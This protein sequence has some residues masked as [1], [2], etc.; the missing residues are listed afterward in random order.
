ME[1]DYDSS[2]LDE[3]SSE[4]NGVMVTINRMNSAKPAGMPEKTKTLFGSMTKVRKP[5]ESNIKTI[6][7]SPKPEPRRK[8]S[9]YVIPTVGNLPSSINIPKNNLATGESKKKSISGTI[10]EI[11]EQEQKRMNIKF[12]KNHNENKLISDLITQKEDLEEF[13]SYLGV[14][15]HIAKCTKSIKGDKV[16]IRLEDKAISQIMHMFG[17]HV[18]KYEVNNIAKQLNNSRHTGGGA[19]QFEECTLRISSAYGYFANFIIKGVNY[20][21]NGRKRESMLICDTQKGVNSYL[22]IVKGEDEVMKDCLNLYETERSQF[23][24]L[25]SLYKNAG[26]KRILI[27]CRYLSPEE[28][29]S[30]KSSIDKILK[31][32]RD[33]LNEHE[34]LANA[35]E[36]DLRFVGCIGVVDNLRADSFK[37]IERLQGSHINISMFS[38]DSLDSCL[39][40]VKELKIS[41]TDFNDPTDYFNLSG[42][43]EQRLRIQVK[44]IIEHLFISLKHS[45]IESKKLFWKGEKAAVS[46]LRELAVAGEH[47][48][49]KTEGSHAEF[50]TTTSKGESRLMKSLLISG[51][52]IDLIRFSK[53]KDL[54]VL[55]RVVLLFTDKIVG[56]SM[57]SHHKVYLTDMLKSIDKIVV[58]VGDGFNDIGMLNTANAGV[59]VFSK[60]VP[61][62]TA[63]VVINNFMDFKE[64]YYSISYRLNKNMY[65]GAILYV[66]IYSA[67]FGI[68][69]VLFF[70]SSNSEIPLD[71]DKDFMLAACMFVDVFLFICVNRPFTHELLRA[72][73]IL[74]RDI[75]FFRLDVVKTTIV[76]LVLGLIESFLISILTGYV[77]I[78]LDERGMPFSIRESS[79]VISI[80]LY[81]NSKV[82]TF[83][84]STRLS[85]KSLFANLVSPVVFGVWMFL[86]NQPGKSSPIEP[87]GLYVAMNS[88]VGWSCVILVC[89][90]CSFYS[91]ITILWFKH[92]FIHKYIHF[93]NL[94]AK[95]NGDTK[96]VLLEKIE[97]RV[98]RDLNYY[99]GN[100]LDQL[101]EK[102]RNLY[103]KDVVDSSLSKLIHVES[104]SYKHSFSNLINRFS[105]VGDKNRF[106]RATIKTLKFSTRIL[107]FVTVGFLILEYLISIKLTLPMDW[108]LYGGIPFYILLITVPILA[109][110]LGSRGYVLVNALKL[111][112]LAVTV[113]SV[114]LS[115]LNHKYL[116]KS[117]ARALTRFCFG[118]TPI[119]IIW[120]TILVAIIESTRVYE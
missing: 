114:S 13:L 36:K 54:A 67:Y 96:A 47:L 49:S 55:L 20:F 81:I 45:S 53:D 120:L 69:A 117:S 2:Q 43:S 71:G 85:R 57:S 16:Y 64:L 115:I 104:V 44:R 6:E 75:L 70:A 86:I 7:P 29:K 91:I 72:I 97:N 78:A 33:Q 3:N 60:S 88:R 37:L 10:K 18:E 28:M 116:F 22:L 48:V 113:I 87:H 61:L 46:S 90:L 35:L 119:D 107:L 80:V 66:W 82:K 106:E 111:F 32:K 9:V 77:G 39:N 41:D 79:A 99:Q 62:I 109:T 24:Q 4:G 84:M 42:N 51:P 40:V 34:K 105:D 21:T 83:L 5:S 59:Q 14:F 74:S 26:F 98:S 89:S 112:M 56:F 93:A 27:G 31:S 50:E 101:I 17:Y 68:A 102:V 12:D 11:V 92:R 76:F 95:K 30:Y 73:P 19:N 15:Q 110:F 63:D 52:S 38:G 103:N 58:G 100:R 118:S 1:C 94:G 23:R 25:I 108:K 8:E 65:I